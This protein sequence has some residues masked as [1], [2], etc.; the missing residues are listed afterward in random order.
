LVPFPPSQPTLILAQKTSNHAL[1]QYQK[2]NDKNERHE[3]NEINV[4]GKSNHHK[5]P[6][7]QGNKIEHQ[8]CLCG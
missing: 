5:Y 8:C 1:V 7:Q 4:E 3:G 2:K 6:M